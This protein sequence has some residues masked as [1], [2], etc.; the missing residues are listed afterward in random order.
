MKFKV[1]VRADVEVNA[2]SAQEAEDKALIFVGEN[3]TF[4]EFKAEPMIVEAE[5]PVRDLKF[6]CE[7]ED[8][9]GFPVPGSGCGEIPCVIFGG[10]SFGDRQLEGVMFEAFIEN[11]EI[12]VRLAKGRVWE[13]D[14]YLV[15]LNKE[16]WMEKALEY[17]KGND[18]AGCP[19]CDSDVDAQPVEDQHDS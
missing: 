6:I 4:L 16:C 11:G 17:A 7:D 3:V 19:Y 10:Y 15:T 14:P 1:K 2:D 8:E 12:A 9:K 13:Q 18:I 5:K